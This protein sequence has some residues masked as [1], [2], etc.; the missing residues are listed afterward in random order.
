ML[1]VADCLFAD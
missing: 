1:A